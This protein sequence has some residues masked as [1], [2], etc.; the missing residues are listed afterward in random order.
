MRKKAERLN[1]D[2]QKEIG[3]RGSLFFA[4]KNPPILLRKP[5]GGVTFG[6]SGFLAFCVCCRKFDLVIFLFCVNDSEYDNKEIA[7]Y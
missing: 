4:I 3:K 6:L 5:A 2:W 7:D 1:K